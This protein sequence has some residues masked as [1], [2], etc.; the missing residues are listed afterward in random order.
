MWVHPHPHPHPPSAH[1]GLRRSSTLPGRFGGP[2]IGGPRFGNDFVL[3]RVLPPTPH[4]L[5]T[6]SALKDQYEEA[7]RHYEEKKAEWR[8]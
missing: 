8:R 2:K 4:E 3:G 5:V 7:K 6:S 1:H